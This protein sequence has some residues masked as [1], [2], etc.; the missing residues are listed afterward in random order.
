M[1]DLALNKYH[2]FHFHKKQVNP[3]K[4]IQTMTQLSNLRSSSEIDELRRVK[5]EFQLEMVTGSGLSSLRLQFLHETIGLLNLA[6]A[7][8]EGEHGQENL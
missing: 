1:H 4:I 2:E 6:L 5:E 8:E 7:H 3:T